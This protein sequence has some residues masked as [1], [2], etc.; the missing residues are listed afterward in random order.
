M[1]LLSPRATRY[2]AYTRILTSRQFVSLLKRKET[3]PVDISKMEVA[4]R[5][6]IHKNLA[7]YKDT[8]THR[9]VK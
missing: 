6:L 2:L 7:Y 3:E 9:V 8:K 4:D 1:L 5:P